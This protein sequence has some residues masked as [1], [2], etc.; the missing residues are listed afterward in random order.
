MGFYWSLESVIQTTYG[1]DKGK[2]VSAELIKEMSEYIK[3]HGLEF[4]WIPALRGRS[5]DYLDNNSSLGENEDSIKE[6]FDYIFPQPNYY[7]VPYS[8]DQ[9]KTIPKWLYEN[10]LYI[11]MEADRTVLGIDCNSDQD[12]P[13]NMRCNIGVCWENCRVSDP[14]LATKYAGDYVSVQ[15]DVIGR[16]FQHRAYYF[17]VALEVIDKLQNYCNVKFGEP[18]V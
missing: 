3:D 8:H 7:Q 6:Y 11:E 4:I 13:E 18:Y 16:K 15:K 5:V 14:T 1:Y 10:D 9:F 17:S 12:C 2:K